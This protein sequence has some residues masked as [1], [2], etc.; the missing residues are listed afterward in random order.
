MIDLGQFLLIFSVFRHKGQFDDF[1]QFAQW[2][3]RSQNAFIDFGHVLTFGL[4]YEDKKFGKLTRE[5]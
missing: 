3:M 1:R 5:R 4:R 2:Y